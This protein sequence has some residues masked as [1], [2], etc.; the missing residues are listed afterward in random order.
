MVLAY[1]TLY[2]SSLVEFCRDSPTL[3]QKISSQGKKFNTKVFRFSTRSLDVHLLNLHGGQDYAVRFRRFQDRCQ[4]CQAF[5]DSKV[6]RPA[7]AAVLHVYLLEDKDVSSL[8]WQ[9]ED[10]KERRRFILKHSAMVS[11]QTRGYQENR[12]K[13]LLQ[14][15]I[16]SRYQRQTSSGHEKY[17]LALLRTAPYDR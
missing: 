12:V 9:C 3:W 6:G 5:P 13:W 7:P 17:P 14:I 16:H 2:N 15:T 10:T 11:Q 8:Q 4:E 1:F